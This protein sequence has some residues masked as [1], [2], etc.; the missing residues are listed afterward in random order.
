MVL[1]VRDRGEEGGEREMGE[2]D[3]GEEGE[4]KEEVRGSG[5][6]RVAKEREERREVVL[7][8]FLV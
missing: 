1:G 8:P 7:V 4:R 5:E 2:R 3:W 6:K